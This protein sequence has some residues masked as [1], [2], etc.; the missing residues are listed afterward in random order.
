MSVLDILEQFR[1]DRQD[2]IIYDL[3]IILGITILDLQYPYPALQ[4]G[5]RII[6]R[7]RTVD[8]YFAHRTG[9][10]IFGV[11][12]DGREEDAL[13]L[14][15]KAVF[16][17]STDYNTAPI[18]RR[19]PT[20]ALMETCIQ[21]FGCSPAGLPYGQAYF[22]H[23]RGCVS[24]LYG[25]RRPAIKQSDLLTVWINGCIPGTRD[26]PVF[27]PLA[28]NLVEQAICLANPIHAF[29]NMGHVLQVVLIDNAFHQEKK[30]VQPS[31][32]TTDT[33]SILGNKP[34]RCQWLLRRIEEIARTNTITGATVKG[35]QA[36]ASGP[37]Q[38]DQH[39]DHH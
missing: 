6:R 22:S 34:V 20:N 39:Q 25:L 31:P 11:R 27:L 4:G 5:R 38:Q 35:V 21:D 7:T 36:I 19:R 8:F 9:N 13:G 33:L 12:V 37:I 28:T 1:F 15:L 10:N 18:G 16:L 23:M 26:D 3:H 24:T 32:E 17:M 2:Y 30:L 29:D 14:Y